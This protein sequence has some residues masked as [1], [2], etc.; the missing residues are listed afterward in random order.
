[1]VDFDKLK[2]EQTELQQKINLE[3]IDIRNI[4]L[5]SGV[6]VAY[7]EIDNEE[8]GV[9]CINIF[10]I[11]SFELVEKKSFISKVEFPYVPG[12][13]AYRELPLIIGAYEKLDKKPDIFMLDGN[14]YLHENHMGIATMFSLTTDEKSIG[15]AK[16]FYNFADANVTV[17]EE[18]FST[19][20][21]IINDE[22]YGYAMRTRTKCN[23]I[24]IS[25]GSG[26]SFENCNELV[27]RCINKKSRIPI[28]TRAADIETHTERRK[29]LTR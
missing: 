24:F 29:I 12:F 18:L 4:R 13:L 16:S 10:D 3:E 9:C 8:Y 11:N 6:D 25:P 20:P 19:T 22:I 23:P 5:I 14:G 26:L 28:P 7:F 1:M 27:K 21:I 2:Q 17:G 15:V